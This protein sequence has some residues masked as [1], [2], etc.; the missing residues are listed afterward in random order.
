MILLEQ[1]V[2][3]QD[4]L[5]QIKPFL[6]LQNLLKTIYTESIQPKA[7]TLDPN[8]K[9]YK[10]KKS[11]LITKINLIKWLIAVHITY[12]MKSIKELYLSQTHKRKLKDRMAKNTIRMIN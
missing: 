12:Y 2:N 5:H 1:Y 4:Y 11:I 7:T 10:Y 3:K 9:T 8:P 6:I